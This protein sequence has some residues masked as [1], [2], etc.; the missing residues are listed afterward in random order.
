MLTIVSW[1]IQYGKGIDGRIDL[2]RI[3]REVRSDGLPDL[4]CLQEV[5][6]ILERRFSSYQTLVCSDKNVFE[7]FCDIHTQDAHTRRNC[8][9]CSSHTNA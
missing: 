5:S 6:R 8:D 1:N 9:A 2:T 7:I 4:L 3:A